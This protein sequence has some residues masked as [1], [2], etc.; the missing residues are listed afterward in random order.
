MLQ[1]VSQN[2]DI[3]RRDRIFMYFEL[4]LITIALFGMIYLLFVLNDLNIFINNYYNYINSR[5]DDLNGRLQ[6]LELKYQLA[7]LY[8]NGTYE[9]FNCL[10]EKLDELNEGFR[11]K[12]VTYDEVFRFVINDE[13]KFNRYQFMRYECSNFAFD[14]CKNALKKGIMCSPVVIRFKN[15]GHVIVAFK[16][17]DRGVVYYDPTADCF[18]NLSVGMHYF[19]DNGLKSRFPI[20]DEVIYFVSLFN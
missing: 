12:E 4:S 9:Y 7:L 13:T 10:A 11:F 16:T 5:L 8:M 1:A 6:D 18:V 14:M 19:R 3:V 2:K 17:V 15:S 20:D